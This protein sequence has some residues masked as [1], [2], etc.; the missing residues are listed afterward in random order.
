MKVSIACGGTG[1]HI[2]PGIATAEVLRARGN[3]VTLWLTGRDVETAAASDW[4][5]AVIRVGAEGFPVRFSL[6]GVRAF[7]KFL[8]AVGACRKLMKEAKPDVVLAMGSYASAGP[9]GAAMTLGVPVV[10]HEANVLP[11]RAIALFSRWAKAVAGCFE[12]TRFYLKNREIILTGMPMRKD[13]DVK[14]AHDLPDGLQEDIFTLLVMGGSQGA[15]KLNDCVAD[16]VCRVAEQGHKLQVI[17]LTGNADEAA[18]RTM[19]QDA[20]IP[21]SV[22]AFLQDMGAAYSYTH[23]AV[24]RSG[25]ATCAELSLYGVPALLVPHPFGAHH[26]QMANA[27][28][29]EKKGAADVVPE[30][31][32]TVSWLVDYIT[33]RIESPG[34]LAAM[35]AASMK[36][37]GKDGADA[38]ADLV[39][40]VARAG[41]R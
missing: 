1:G 39:L 17:H 11:G 29:M 2:F 16:A 26:H 30:Q 36:R 4:S 18:V 34:R 25:A 37:G 27:R 20:G 14:I 22:H 40:D 13:L 8:K 12:E 32:M 31:D 9:V 23:L 33:E 3:D 10:L 5:G 21:H 24:C 6:R 15:H 28:A 35:S 41:V 7:W 38:L 19:Y